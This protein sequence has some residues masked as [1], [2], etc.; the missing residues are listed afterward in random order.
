M[1]KI[2]IGALVLLATAYLAATGCGGES[3]HDPTDVCTAHDAGL[4]YGGACTLNNDC[5]SCVC[6]YFDGDHV[7]QCTIS[8]KTDTECPLGSEGHKCSG[9]GFCKPP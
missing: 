2:L 5:A 6:H 8:C 9:E 7:T 4:S 3:V 1:R